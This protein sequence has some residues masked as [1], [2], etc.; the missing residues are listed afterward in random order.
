MI[1]IHE[2]LNLE[3]IIYYRLLSIRDYHLSNVS[4]LIVESFAILAQRFGK[5]TTTSSDFH[6][7]A[8]KLHLIWLFL[9]IGP[10]FII[11]EINLG[12]NDCILQTRA[13]IT[14]MG[15]GC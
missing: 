1:Q 5:T 3:T 7:M 11:L 10:S 9:G 6:P 15:I 13:T 8:Q 2:I 4:R 14:L 12:P